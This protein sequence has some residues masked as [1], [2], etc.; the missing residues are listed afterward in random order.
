M[1]ENMVGRGEDDLGRRDSI[2]KKWGSKNV[3]EE[4]GW[5]GLERLPRSKN[6]MEENDGGAWVEW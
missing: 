1:E 2:L 6:V 4:N 3:T 5:K